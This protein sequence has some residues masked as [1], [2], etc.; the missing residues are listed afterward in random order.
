MKKFKIILIIILIIQLILLFV[1]S[2]T[3]T[4]S[5][6][7]TVEEIQT[8]IKVAKPIVNVISSEP[9]VINNSNYGGV[10]NFKVQNYN[11]DEINEANLVYTIEVIINNTDNLKEIKLK[12]ITN[13]TET[14]ISLS[15]NKTNEIRLKKETKQEDSYKLYLSYENEDTIDNVKINVNT[16]QVQS[17]EGD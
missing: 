9:L 10:Y 17:E 14:D 12:K 7:K 8:S 6:F 3:Y 13:G 1:N 5:C 11:G 4:Y 2:I 16:V 15:D